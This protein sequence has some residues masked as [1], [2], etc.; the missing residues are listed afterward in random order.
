MDID[1]DIRAA[2]QASTVYFCATSFILWFAYDAREKGGGQNNV[3]FFGVNLFTFLLFFGAAARTWHMARSNVGLRVTNHK[4]SL[5][6]RDGIFHLKMFFSSI[7]LAIKR[8]KRAFYNNWG[9]WTKLIFSSHGFS[10]SYYK[11]WI[12]FL[13]RDLDFY[14]KFDPFFTFLIKFWII[15]EKF[16]KILK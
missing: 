5:I 15:I 8:T 16:E 4:K 2:A 11:S 6:T 1:I 7:P 14:K 9:I 10:V 3:W 13:V 12:Q